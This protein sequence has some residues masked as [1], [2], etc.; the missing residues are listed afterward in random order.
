MEVSV[1]IVSY[2]VKEFLFQCIT[3]LL[4]FSE[5]GR[6][7]IIVVDNNS[8]DGSV[9]MVRTHF[10][11]ARLIV[12]SSNAGFP[13]ANN[14]ALKIA[15]G[16]FIYLLNPDTESIMDSIA[17]LKRYLELHAD[18]DLV[19]PQLLNSDRSIQHS[20]SR[21]PKI[22]Y[23]IAEM[24][25]FDRFNKRKYYLEKDPDE[26][27]EIDAAFGAALFFRKTL[28]NK[29]GMLNEKLFWIEDIDYCYR[30]KQAGGKIL[31]LPE[32]KLVHHSGQS[33]KKNYTVSVSNQVINKIKFYKVHHNSGELLIVYLLSITNALMRLVVF[34]LL[35]PFS[36]IYFLKMKAY[37]L[38]IPKLF[39]ATGGL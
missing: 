14:Q 28:L 37:W 1:I 17:V 15:T 8:E 29:I 27:I 4:K 38:T 20:I 31:Y 39:T 30:I 9:E 18:V 23:L 10:P 22:R 24:F 5:A 7:E 16:E 33:A 6:L 35:S 26:Q 19:A 32:A 34:T 12:N 25:Y 36:K 13:V 2:N 3:S 21:F 11:K